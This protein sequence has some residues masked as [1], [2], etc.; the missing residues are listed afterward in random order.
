M[1]TDTGIRGWQIGF[2]PLCK[3]RNNNEPVRVRSVNPIG[4]RNSVVFECV[5]MH[6]WTVSWQ[7]PE[8]KP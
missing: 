3:R 5:Q 2:C 4:L 1:T 7:E 6:V 8:D